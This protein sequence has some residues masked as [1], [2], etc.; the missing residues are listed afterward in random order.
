V[1]NSIGPQWCDEFDPP[2]LPPVEAAR[3]EFAYLVVRRLLDSSVRM[4]VINE[5]GRPAMVNC[6]ERLYETLSR[7]CPIIG[8]YCEGARARDIVDDLKAAGL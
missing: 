1:I 5:H 3:L 7:D 6:R 2:E 8:V 4:A